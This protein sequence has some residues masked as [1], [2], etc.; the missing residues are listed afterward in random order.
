MK[1]ENRWMKYFTLLTMVYI[2]YFLSI[3]KF[4]YFNEPNELNNKTKYESSKVNLYTRGISLKL[5][6]FNSEIR[7]RKKKE[8]ESVRKVLQSHSKKETQNQ[9]I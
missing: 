6:E 5:I 2:F 4:Q 1:F 3:I 7:N 9:P 8:E